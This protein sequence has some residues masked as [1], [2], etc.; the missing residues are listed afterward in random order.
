[1]RLG[2]AGASPFG[3]GFGGSVYAVVAA[4][5]AERFTSAWRADYGQAFPAAA[6][7]AEFLAGAPAH[8]AH[9]VSSG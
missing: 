1:V 3:A 5:D 8:G 9:E 4:G 2:A 6:E 7:R